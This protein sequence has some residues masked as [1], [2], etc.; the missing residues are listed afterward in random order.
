MSTVTERSE[1]PANGDAD[2]T[3]AMSTDAASSEQLGVWRLAWRVSQHEPRSFWLGWGLF[4]LFFT[5]PAIT[6][7]LLSRGFSE[8]QNGNE[9]GVFRWAL[10]SL[11]VETGRMISIHAGALMFTRS[12]VHMQTFLRANLLAAQVASG[13]PEAGQPVG[14]PARRSPTSATTRRTW[15]CSSTAW[16]T[17]PRGSC[18]P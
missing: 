8:L 7:Y 12:W 15:R 3:D 6:G 11:A 13:G 1:V 9:S 4:V 10:A 18:S 14:P 2:I 5:A 17:C 16:S